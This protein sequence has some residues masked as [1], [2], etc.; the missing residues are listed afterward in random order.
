MDTTYTLLEDIPPNIADSIEEGY[1]YLSLNK[2]ASYGM[3]EAITPTSYDG[4]LINPLVD[5]DPNEL[6]KKCN[7]PPNYFLV[8]EDKVKEEIAK[9]FDISSWQGDR[10]FTGKFKGW[11]N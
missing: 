10:C 2:Q 5:I 8:K 11:K 9:H 3:Y 6:N 1:I 7:L 4:T